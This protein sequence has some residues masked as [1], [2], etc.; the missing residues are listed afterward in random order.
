M[1]QQ[2]SSGLAWATE[3]QHSSG[4]AETGSLGKLSVKHTFLKFFFFA[5][6][7]FCG[8]GRGE[9][10]PWLCLGVRVQ[11][12]PPC[13]FWELNSGRLGLWQTP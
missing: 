1:E 13:E 4:H 3:Q 8:W 7:L 10:V 12:L 2:H 6:Y 9:H 5:L 11:L